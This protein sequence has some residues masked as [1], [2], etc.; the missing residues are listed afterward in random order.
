MFVDDHWLALG[1]IVWVTLAAADVPVGMHLCYGDYGHQ[2]FTQPES[3]AL[4]VEL[5]ND[6][7]VTLVLDTSW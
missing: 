2:H 6:G 1:L 7:P 3:L 4:Q 5:V